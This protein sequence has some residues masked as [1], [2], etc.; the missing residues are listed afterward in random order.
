M[1]CPKCS[2]QRKPT[3]TAVEGECPS[4]GIIYAKYREPG[5][6]PPRQVIVGSAVLAEA[7]EQLRAGWSEK[8][9]L[10][11]LV[12]K[13]YAA[14]AAEEILDDV[15]RMTATSNRT[16]GGGKVVGGV[17]MVG[18]IGIVLWALHSVGVRSVGP[19]WGVPIL[20][21]AGLVLRGLYQLLTGDSDPGSD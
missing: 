2:Y 19:V 15:R 20:I 8:Q 13:G 1:R 4:C 3:D 6:Q 9:V 14:D 7:S 12:K 21:G 5:S 11:R 18:G 10:A 16:E 17:I